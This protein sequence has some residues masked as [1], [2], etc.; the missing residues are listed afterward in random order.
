[1]TWGIAI[2]ALEFEVFYPKITTAIKMAK[3]IPKPPS[4]RLVT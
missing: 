3:N 2:S 4:S 1:M